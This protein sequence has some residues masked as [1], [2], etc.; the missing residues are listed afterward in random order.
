MYD[1]IVTN[2]GYESQGVQ[3]TN[4]NNKIGRAHV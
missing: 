1:I 2:P 4:I 3:V